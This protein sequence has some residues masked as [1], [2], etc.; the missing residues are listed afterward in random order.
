MKIF[1]WDFHG[2]LE[3]G[4]EVGFWHILKL[5]AKDHG[6]QENFKLTEV[7]RLYGTSVGSYLKH[8]FPSAS[9]DEIKRMMADVAAIQNQE[10]LKK[11]VKAANGAI[12]ILTKIKIAGHKNIVLSNSHPKHINPLIKI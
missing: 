7:R 8:F 10:H 11:Y 6:I 3:Q 4:V 12:P 2:T 9:E 1:A 5:I